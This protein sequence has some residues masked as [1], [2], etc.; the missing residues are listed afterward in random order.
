M[1]IL[2]FI[3]IVSSLISCFCLS[4]Y[5]HHHICDV[6]WPLPRSF[7]C[8]STRHRGIICDHDYPLV[9]QVCAASFDLIPHAYFWITAPSFG[10]CFFLPSHQPSID[11][12][13]GLLLDFM[14]WPTCPLFGFSVILQVVEAT[15]QQVAYYCFAL[16]AVCCQ[17]EHHAI[18]IVAS[19]SS[20]S[21]SFVLLRLQYVVSQRIMPS[22]MSRHHQVYCDCFSLVTPATIMALSFLFVPGITAWFM[23]LT[24]GLPILAWLTS[25]SSSW[26]R[27]S[28][29][30][31]EF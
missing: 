17:P 6:F 5:G 4:Q 31:F 1:A 20:F 21:F 7:E 29:P 2:K 14:V 16:V 19:S 30:A 13:H 25:W 8:R 28:T 9:S 24:V 23:L 11:S 3:T 10:L 15:H 18:P 12:R 27:T 22:N 26:L